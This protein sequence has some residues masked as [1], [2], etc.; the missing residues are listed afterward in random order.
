[1]S[2]CWRKIS[3]SE[4]PLGLIYAV[5]SILAVAGARLAVDGVA[6][7]G[8]FC[9]FKFITGIPCPTCG[10]TR[11]YAAVSHLDFAQALGLNPLMVIVLVGVW[12]WGLVS[13]SGSVYRGRVPRI[14][15]T[16]N[17]ATAMR[18]FVVAAIAAN[19]AYLIAAGV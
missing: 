11:A 1:M 3:G 6:F 19:W 14:S 8:Y 7:K 4:L 9:P 18:V 2:L 13:F 15:A 16:G 17:A 12:I 10:I 5:I